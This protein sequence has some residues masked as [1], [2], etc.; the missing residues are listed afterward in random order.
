MPLPPPAPAQVPSG[1]KKQPLESIIPLAKV[2]EA[3]ALVMFRAVPW[4]P[5]EK[6]EVPVP[7]IVSIP[8]PFMFPEEVVVAKPFIQRLPAIDS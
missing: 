8:C 1:I 6:V 7:S 2:E 5:P 3:V 4:M